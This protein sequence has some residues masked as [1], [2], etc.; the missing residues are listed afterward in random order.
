MRGRAELE[1]GLP[2]DVGLAQLVEAFQCL[3]AHVPLAVLAGL[4][5][6]SAIGTPIEIDH[7]FGQQVAGGL[8]APILHPLVAQP[9]P[10]VPRN[11][12]RAMVSVDASAAHGRTARTA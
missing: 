5:R 12:H 3:A 6:T 11:P 2:A 4:V 1:T 8:L 7:R 9:L 10:R